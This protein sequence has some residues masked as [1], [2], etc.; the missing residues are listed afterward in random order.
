M[1]VDGK[2]VW[3]KQPSGPFTR[4]NQI[5]IRDHFP[6]VVPF[7]DPLA[8]LC[9]PRPYNRPPVPEATTRPAVH[10]V[11]PASPRRQECPLEDV[12]HSPRPGCATELQAAGGRGGRRQPGAGWG[13]RQPVAEHRR[14]HT[15]P[16]AVQ[17]PIWILPRHGGGRHQQV[18]PRAPPGDHRQWGPL[19]AQS[20]HHVR[21]RFGLRKLRHVHRGRQKDRRGYCERGQ[22]R[23]G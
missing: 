1:K 12:H 4:H 10:Q 19:G 15:G 20:N 8:R 18:I 5:L 6:S 7:L 16:R 17:L 2:P 22:G 9:K 14:R 3:R 11:R 23:R 13:C 21:H